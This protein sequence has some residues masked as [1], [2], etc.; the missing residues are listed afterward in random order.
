MISNVNA[1]SDDINDVTFDIE[2]CGMQGENIVINDRTVTF[3]VNY[4]NG[5]V[6]EVELLIWTDYV[7]NNEYGQLIEL[8][9]VT[10]TTSDGMVGSMNNIAPVIYSKKMT[11]ETDPVMHWWTIDDG[12]YVSNTMFEATKPEGYSYSVSIATTQYSANY[13]ERVVTIEIYD[14]DGELVDTLVSEPF[15][16]SGEAFCNFWARSSEGKLFVGRLDGKSGNEWLILN[17]HL[18]GEGVPAWYD[19]TNIYAQLR[20]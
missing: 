15:S 4:D 7:N 6:S 14:K 12:E 18:T 9:G 11:K 19:G 10:T 5:S 2:Y 16:Y 3:T 8:K 20:K 1:P 13:G 17:C